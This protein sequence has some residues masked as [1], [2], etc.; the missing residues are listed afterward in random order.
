V[1]EDAPVPALTETVRAEMTKAALWLVRSIGYGGAA[2][3]EYLYDPATEE[4]YFLE[5]NTRIQIEHRVSEM[6]TGIDLVTSQLR[7]A[8]AEKPVI[9][10]QQNDFAITGVVVEARVYAENPPKKNSYPSLGKS[11]S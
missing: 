11:S 6:I 3:V 7:C 1:I 8:M 5:M 4:F 10:A 2:T 9:L